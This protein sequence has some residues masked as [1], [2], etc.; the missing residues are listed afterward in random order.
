MLIGHE[1]PWATWRAAL[2]GDRMHHGWILAGKAGLGK[3]AFAAA[4]ARELVAEAGQA[5]PATGAHPDIITLSHLPAS[6]TDEK[7]R[8]EGKPF[9]VKRSIGIAQIREMQHRLVTRPTLGTRR[10]IIIDPADD[11][12]KP[13]ANALLKSL[14]EPPAGTF[15][16]LVSHRPGRLLPTIRSRCRLLRFPAVDDAAI[17]TLL[18]DAVPDSDGAAR[19]AAI[20]AAQGAPGTALQFIKEDL[21]EIYALM[22]QIVAEGDRGFSHRGKLARAIGARPGR[23]RIQAVMELA[24]GALSSQMRTADGQR[25]ARVIE[26]HSRLSKLTGIAPTYNFD[27]GLLIMDIGTLLAQAA[28]D[29]EAA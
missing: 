22:R 3:A 27:P 20:A 7:K 8:E 12:E 26:A 18:R 28:P 9:E 16:L 1:E 19:A 17:D 23:E 21:A 5:M 13:A 10:A 24:R 11:L 15:F 14:E 25:L 2:A 6:P 29:R 4:A